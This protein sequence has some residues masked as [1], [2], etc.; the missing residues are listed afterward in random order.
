M[1]AGSAIVAEDLVMEFPTGEDDGAVRVLYGLSLSI[2][3]GASLA[4]VGPSGCGKSTLLG[5]LG[6]LDVP[7]SG[8][9]LIGEE[10]VSAL[11]EGRRAAIRRS[12]IGFVFQ[13]DN[14]QPFLTVFENVVL[15][16]VLAGDP[17]G[18]ARAQALLADLGLADLL[19]RLP[20][21]LSGG[22]RQRVAVARALVHEPGVVLADEP[23]GALDAGTSERVVDLLLAA[24]ERLGCT[25]VVVTHDP[26]VA[27]RMS[28]TVRL[29]DGRISEQIES[30]RVG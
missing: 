30:S 1:R 10:E 11:S 19:Q 7:T 4:V 18:G 27:R 16:C 17:N 26:D 6:G 28:A 5:L 15:Q 20:N 29:H 3:A 8:R 2:A 12:E 21:E 24:R 22:Q 9:V 13:A 14:L 25:L 23:T